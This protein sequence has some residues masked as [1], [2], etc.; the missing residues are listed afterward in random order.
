MD[1][2]T[3]NVSSDS[4]ESEGVKELENYQMTEDGG[5]DS[6]TIA[7][8]SPTTEGT[9]SGRKRK[10]VHPR[11]PSKEKTSRGS[12]NDKVSDSIVRLADFLACGNP[13]APV[14]NVKNDEPSD[15]NAL[16][17][18]RIEDLTITAKDKIGIAAYLSNPNQETS[19]GFLKTAM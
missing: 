14:Q 3:V 18:K 5:N 7:R 8:N 2:S 4:D 1:Q 16:L 13:A 10:R 6:D 17:W 12:L 9:S 11:N 19:R 15:P